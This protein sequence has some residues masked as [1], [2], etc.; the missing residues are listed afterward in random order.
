[1]CKIFPG[2]IDG[3]LSGGAEL[4]TSQGEKNNEITAQITEGW[5][6]LGRCE[7]GSSR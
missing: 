2:N 1:M 4:G 5:F 3:N 7:K 6:Y